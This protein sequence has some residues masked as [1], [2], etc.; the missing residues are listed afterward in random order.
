[1]IFL[2]LAAIGGMMSGDEETIKEEPNISEVEEIEV[3]A[4]EE[5]IGKSDEDFS[6]ITKSKPAKVRNDNTGNWRITTIANNIDIEK[7]ALSYYKN[8]FDSDE[9]IHAIVNFNYNT[10]TR[11]S[12]MGSSILVVDILEYVDKEEHDA[13]KLFGGIHLA[14][15]WIY[16]DNGDIEKIE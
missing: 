8:N 14:T 4:R 13:N 11:I 2:V 16:L 5:A 12:V 1:M 15:Y 10:T 3:P 9:E 6:N 7:Y